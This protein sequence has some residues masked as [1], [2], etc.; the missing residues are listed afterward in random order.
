MNLP[1]NYFITGIALAQHI[2]KPTKQ[3]VIKYD[4]GYIHDIKLM[5][6]NDCIRLLKENI[7]EVK[8][9]FSPTDVEFLSDQT[10][11]ILSEL[12]INRKK[13]VHGLIL[14]NN[15]LF[16]EYYNGED[17]A[18]VAGYIGN[19]LDSFQNRQRVLDG[20][21]TTKKLTLIDEYWIEGYVP[22]RLHFEAL[23][24]LIKT[25]RIQYSKDL[26][27]NSI[28]M[29]RK[30]KYILKMVKLLLPYDLDNQEIIHLWYKVLTTGNWEVYC[31][32]IDRYGFPD[33]TTT[34]RETSMRQAMIGDN[35][36]IIKICLERIP[37][38]PIEDVL[39]FGYPNLLK[40]YEFDPI[41]ICRNSVIPKSIEHFAPIVDKKELLRIYKKHPYKCRNLLRKYID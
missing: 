8:S 33:L 14:Y 28:F 36:K 38:Y 35:V 20:L 22:F 19:F 37:K 9:V 32:Y 31:S 29:N 18:F 27:L 26:L 23:E 12:G 4:H 30:S 7:E 16:H 17:I 2:H 34:N 10:I 25:D 5:L 39:R 13:L 3:Q 40:Y 41:D 21:L 11:S 6:K 15:P 1:A 24:Y